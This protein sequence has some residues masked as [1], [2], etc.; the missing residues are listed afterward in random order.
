VQEGTQSTEPSHDSL[1]KP[2]ATAESD[3][4]ALKLSASVEAPVRNP[5]LGKDRPEVSQR[6]QIE[7]RFVAPNKQT[8]TSTSA[9]P[10]VKAGDS[11]TPL[12]ISKNAPALQDNARPIAEGAKNQTAH[13]SALLAKSTG[14]MP[15]LA[16][17]QA[18]TSN[19]AQAQVQA[20]AQQPGSLPPPAL[21]PQ[22]LREIRQTAP[23][24]TP[25]APSLA[26]QPLP[27][28]E[29][30]I[31]LSNFDPEIELAALQPQ[32]SNSAP[33]TPSITP[34]TH[35]NA[36]QVASQIVAA[37]SQSSGTTTEIL[38]NPE[39]LGRVRISL[40]NGEAG[41]TVNIL[42]ERGETAELMRR[43]IE[44]LARELRDLGYE[45]PSFTF[46]ERSDGSNDTWDDEHSEQAPETANTATQPPT[47]S[48]QVTL[49]GGLDLK[50]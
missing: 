37:I 36:P 49:S 44:L 47:S 32:N 41:M 11:S 28:N 10:I 33:S 23:K 19:K 31:P 9:Q 21:P 26:I 29:L 8:Q 16:A 25:V 4:N 42:A 12:P 46:G 45:N 3:P 18:L 1:Q 48:M 5:V 40:T 15:P 14:Q 50:L 13:V 34:V 38:L 17:M 27:K 30:S 22:E 39:E 24:P 35:S 43:N 6:H 20:T 2:Q 7:E